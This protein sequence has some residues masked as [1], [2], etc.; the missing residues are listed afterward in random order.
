MRPPVLKPGLKPGEKDWIFAVASGVSEEQPAAHWH[1]ERCGERVAT[2]FPIEITTYV[3]MMKGF[4]R[5]H[6][7]CKEPKANKPAETGPNPP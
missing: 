3:E 2:S 5:V 1:C 4:A 7:G 6:R